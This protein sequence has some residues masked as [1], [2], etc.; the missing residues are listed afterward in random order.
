MTAVA[1]R[2]TQVVRN[3]GDP[4][5]I[6]IIRIGSPMAILRKSDIPSSEITDKSLYLNRRAFI[7]AAPT[8]LAL[9]RTV[10]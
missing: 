10:T 8:R 6:Y 9:A 4:P 2:P 3:A 7:R 5:G 1:D